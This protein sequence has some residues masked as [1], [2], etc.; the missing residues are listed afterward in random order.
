MTQH[1]GRTKNSGCLIVALHLL[2]A[3]LCPALGAEPPNAE[4]LRAYVEQNQHRQ[5][6]G[7]YV[8]NRK[9]GWATDELKLGRHAGRDAAVA[10]FEMHGSFTAGGETSRSDATSATYYDLEGPGEIIFAEERNVEDGHETRITVEREGAGLVIRT[11]SPAGETTR[12][13]PVPKETLALTRQL[14]RWLAQPPKKRAQFVSY[15]AAWDRDEIDLKEIYTFRGKKPLLWG[16]IKT[17]VYLVALNV[18]GMVMDFEVAADGTPLRGV[19]GGLFELRAEKEALAKA[20]GT[21]P[22]DMLEA[23]AIK[24]NRALG[25]PEK[26]DSLVLNVSGLGKFNIPTS[27]RQRVRSRLGG[28]LVL[29]TSR[30][31]PTEVS[32]PLSAGERERYQKPTPALQSSHETIQS[33]ARQIIGSEEDVLEKATLLKQ[34]VF[35]NMRQT[36]AA[37]QSTALDVLNSR[38]GDCTEITMLF[39]ALARAAGIPAR[40]VGGVMYANEGAPLF[41]WH[42][43][44]EIHDGHQWVS[45]DPTW[46][47]V[48]VD[49]THIK[50]SEDVNDLAWVNILGKVKIKV[51]GF[52]KR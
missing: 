12:H 39:V 28:I 11:R 10:L 3:V 38:A 7:V 44:A 6:Y 21:E 15:S 35:Q 40:E 18:D 24:V 2:A 19:M 31:R 26:I 51:I 52:I 13:V 41:G 25:D 42:A 46:N 45:V 22:I 1:T 5:A 37:N 32:V 20:P 17:T 9:F 43:W 29:E 48:Y 4:S 49:A 33:Q 8:K 23:S 34:W 16:G 14:E 50:L 36:M 27:H 30:D 47:Q